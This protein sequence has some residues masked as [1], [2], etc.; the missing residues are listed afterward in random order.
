ME[1]TKLEAAVLQRIYKYRTFAPT[2]R[3]RLRATSGIMGTL[4]LLCVAM[5]VLLAR[6]KIPGVAF[7]PA[8]FFLGALVR[9]IGNQ[10][11]WVKLWPVNREITDWN[12]VEQLLNEAK[13]AA[14]PDPVPKTRIKWA[15]GVGLGAFAVVLGFTV[16]TDQA[17]AYIYNPTR[18]NPSHSVIVLTAS[19]CP[20]CESLR[21]HL[22]ELRVPYTELDVDHT[23]EG[24]FGFTAVRGTG[25]PITIVG[26][27]VL[28]GAGKNGK[29]E[30][31]DAALKEAGY[32]LAPATH[33]VP[34][35]HPGPAPGLEH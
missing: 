34:E 28:R 29:W 12:R 24:R 4:L 13:T 30:K 10:R 3:G 11:L 32:P 16:G 7:L 27:H 9:D 21:R 8:G 19:W 23:T 20:Y 1:L 14:R 17:L 6:L 2:L 35:T 33:V 25:I 22:L 15:V 31:I 18:N 5:G 26:Q